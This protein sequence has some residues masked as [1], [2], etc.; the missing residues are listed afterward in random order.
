VIF[1]SAAYFAAASLTMSA[2]ME[3]SA[4]IQPD[5]VFHFLP[6]Q[7]WIRPERVPSWS[8]QDTLIGCSPFSNPSC[9][10]RSAVR[11][12]FSRPHLTRS[13]VKGS[14]IAIYGGGR[15]ALAAP[16]LEEDELI[17]VIAIYR[18]KVR[19][20]T[21]KQIE[22]VTNFA[23]QAVIALENTRLLK[24]LRQRTDNLTESLE[25]QTATSEV[26]RVMSSSPGE[27]EPAFEA[28]LENATRLC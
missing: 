15:T 22:L 9:L 28:M 21:E 1:F 12:R 13:P 25:Q 6:S 14:G 7:V 26:L 20:F 11:L 27:L 18:Q 24:E 23:Q 4:V 3:S 16:M 2:I 17:G 10:R 8:A 19:P 5:T